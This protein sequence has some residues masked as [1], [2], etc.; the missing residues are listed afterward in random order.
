MMLGRFEIACEFIAAIMNTTE[1][2]GIIEAGGEVSGFQTHQQTGQVI[3]GAMG[4]N[5]LPGEL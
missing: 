3:N 4:V 2:G 5:G 1:Q